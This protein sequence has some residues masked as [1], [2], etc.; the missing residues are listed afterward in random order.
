MEADP[1]HGEGG[2][3]RALF[4]AIFRSIIE[5]LFHR[6]AKGWDGSDIHRFDML[7]LAIT[8]L[9]SLTFIFRAPSEW[10]TLF[11]SPG[12]KWIGR[13]R[14][15]LL[16]DDCLADTFDN[17][18]NVTST[19]G[20][21]QGHKAVDRLR[22]GGMCGGDLADCVFTIFEGLTLKSVFHFFRL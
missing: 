13:F 1:Y 7:T 10:L 2:E 17:L 3:V 22:R 15:Y 6:Y 4:C 18:T 8:T 14:N 20:F 9:L 5:A 12:E 19:R 16:C 11:A 21:A